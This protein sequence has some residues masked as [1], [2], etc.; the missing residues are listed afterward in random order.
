MIPSQTAELAHL[1]TARTLYYKCQNPYLV[2]ALPRIHRAEGGESQ[3]TATG[4]KN[5]LKDMVDIIPVF[6][7]KIK[8]KE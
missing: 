7:N 1:Q 4:C 2:A 8:I 5:G 3:C 6:I